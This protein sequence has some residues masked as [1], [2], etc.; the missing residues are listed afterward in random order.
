M[1]IAP[2]M[3]LTGLVPKD[4]DPSMGVNDAAQNDG[5]DDHE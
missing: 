1:P 3:L 2:R 5:G 4:V